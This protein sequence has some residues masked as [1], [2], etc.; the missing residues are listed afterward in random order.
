ML[1]DRLWPRGI[2]KR[3]FQPDLWAKGAAPS[4]SLR[5]WVHGGGD[6]AEFERRYRAELDASLDDADVQALLELVRSAEV[7]L[8]FAAK[9]RKRNYAHVLANWL[10]ER[11]E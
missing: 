5:K 2:S 4:T 8:V 10:R 11:V 7:T 9:D 1:V 6:W 3:D